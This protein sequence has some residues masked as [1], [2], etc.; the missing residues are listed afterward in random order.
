MLPCSCRMCCTMHNLVVTVLFR[1]GRSAGLDK[2]GLMT[3]PSALTPILAPRT[4]V[5]ELHHQ[6]HEACFQLRK[7]TVQYPAV[8]HNS[9]IDEC[10]VKHLGQNI[11][12]TFS[13]ADP[14]SAA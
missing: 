1:L 3:A 11:T 12:G 2:S 8:L 6:S 5:I 4:P 7:G 13:A 9:I 10:L 14:F